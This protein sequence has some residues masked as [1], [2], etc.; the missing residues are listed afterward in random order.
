MA[1]FAAGLA[2]FAEGAVLGTH[3]FMATLREGGMS[4]EACNSRVGTM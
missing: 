1:P 2:V 4:A 3:P